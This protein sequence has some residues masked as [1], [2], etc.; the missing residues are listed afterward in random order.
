MKRSNSFRLARANLNQHKLRTRLS[1]LG[2]II[3]VFLVSI[4][5]IISNSIKQSIKK[6]L[7]ELPNNSIVINGASNNQFLSFLNLPNNTLNKKDMDN[8]SQ[9]STI[10]AANLFINSTVNSKQK[11]Y[12][13]ITTIAS[14]IDGPSKIFTRMVSGNWYDTGADHRFAVLGEDI[15]NKILGT[16]KAMNQVISIKGE[17]FMVV[18]VLKHIHNPLSLYGYNANNSIFISLA[19]GQAITK[20]DSLGQIVIKEANINKTKLAITMGRNHTDSS[21]YTL[22]NIKDIA[23]ELDQFLSYFTVALF[24]IAVVLAIISSVSIANLMLV[25]VIERQR[26]IGIRKAV[27]ATNRNIISQFLLESLIM[28]VRGG[29]IGLC[30]AYLVAGIALLFYG[31]PLSFSWSAL[32]IGSC[33]PIAV[34]VLAGFY[35]AYRAA[36]QDIAIILNR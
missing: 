2:I 8:L 19:N 15:A 30:L 12:P 3:S 21:E 4:V 36:K 27:G 1:I 5:L 31:I 32:F 23:K 35:P 7:S 33:L 26:E 24:S 20:S 29:M 6:Q 16:N 17:R 9:V 34:G 28:S 22:L 11:E 14:T 18:G 13:N 25:N 10:V